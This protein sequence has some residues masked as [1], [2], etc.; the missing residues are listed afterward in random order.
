MNIPNLP[1]HELY[2]RVQLAAARKNLSDCRE[3]ES[4]ALAAYWDAVD[5]VS[6]AYRRASAAF[7]AWERAAKATE[8][9]PVDGSIAP[10]SDYECTLHSR[11]KEPQ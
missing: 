9:K 11:N 1:D 8:I 6:K 2:A 5:T 7:Y 3:R 4:E 10:P